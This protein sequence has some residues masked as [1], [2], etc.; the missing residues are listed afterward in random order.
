MTG[1][2]PLSEAVAE[3]AEDRVHGASELARRSLEVLSQ[4]A[5]NRPTGDTERLRGEL[6]GLSGLLAVARPSMVPIANLIGEWR[7]AV[8][9]AEVSDVEELRSLAGRLAESLIE[10]SVLAVESAGRA[11]AERIGPGKRVI[12]LSSSSTVRAAFRRLAGS[13]VGAIV[14]E[15]RPGYEGRDT[16][17]FLAALGIDTQLVTDAQLGHF[18][19][20][21]D[22]ALVG[23][24]AV[25]G[26]GSVVNKA[27]T[28]LLA[29][30]ARDRGIPFWVCCE[31]FKRTH[32]KAETFELEEMSPDEVLSPASANPRPRNLYFEVTPAA[33]VTGVIDEHSAD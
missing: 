13:G 19:A 10:R 6:L 22:A 23:A 18:T 20:E 25:L 3:I 27:G 21:S 2:D 7:D 24:D 30:A 28:Y 33:H 17:S 11:A 32:E 8:T 9:T 31:S 12:T 26:D 1:Q 14:A 15:S 29:L 16:A 5:R 4:V